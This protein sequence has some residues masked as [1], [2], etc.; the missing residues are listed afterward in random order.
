EVLIRNIA[1]DFLNTM[2]RL[3]IAIQPPV[4]GRTLAVEIL[5]L[6][7]EPRALIRVA[8]M[9]H[10]VMELC[11]GDS[12]SPQSLL[13]GF[14]FVDLLLNSITLCKQF[15]T[16]LLIGT[17]LIS[18][19]HVEFIVGSLVILS[20]RDCEVTLCISAETLLL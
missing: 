1:N 12:R 7:V 15:F 5:V 8:R 11:G 6:L 2:L 19:D 9:A 14:K 17:P 3:L 18:L 10:Q 13:S 16:C 20:P 4:M